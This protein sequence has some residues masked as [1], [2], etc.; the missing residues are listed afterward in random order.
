MV[1]G[2]RA[3]LCVSALAAAAAGCHAPHVRTAPF[4]ARPDSV[5]AGDLRGPFSGRVVDADTG[6]PVAG[7]LVYATWTIQRGYALTAP[8]GVREQVTATNADGRYTI[9]RLTNLPAGDRRLSDVHI[10]IYKRGYVAYRSD[11]RFSDLGLR[12]DFAQHHQQVRLIRWRN[13]MSHARHLRYIGGGAAIAS[14]TKWELVDAARELGGALHQARP[15]FTAPSPGRDLRG[16]AAVVAARLIRA[17][18]ITEV[19]GFDGTF[20]TGPLGD[21]PDTA[22]YSSLHLRALD[23][24]ESFDVALRL[25]KLSPK[26]AQARY[27]ELADSLPSS[28][29]TDEIAD[30]SLRTAEGSIRGIAFLDGRRGAVVLLTCGVSQCR[31]VEDAVALARRVYDRLEA[32]W[33]LGALDTP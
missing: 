13:D 6:R 1:S 7:A 28:E 29:A 17:A 12:T 11:R 20:E 27:G 3:A 23:R 33:P 2:L 8:G 16:A 31:T 19:T 4:R 18:D 30:R 10:V 25:W 14:L 26:D 5:A 21:A 15:R 22:H 32:A 9:A 24:P